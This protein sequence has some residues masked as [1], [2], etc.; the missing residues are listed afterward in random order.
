MKHP[1]DTVYDVR[2]DFDMKRKIGTGRNIKIFDHIPNRVDVQLQEYEN[3]KEEGVNWS[4]VRADIKSDNRIA[5][6]FLTEVKI[7][8]RLAKMLTLNTGG[9]IL[10]VV[11]CLQ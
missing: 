7:L 4:A 10:R 2:R 1:A 3:K 8:C 6:Y 9:T 11:S 5:K